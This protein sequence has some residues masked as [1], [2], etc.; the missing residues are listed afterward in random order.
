MIRI[1]KGNLLRGETEALVNTVNCVGPMGKGIALQFKKDIPGKFRTLSERMP[2]RG[3]AARSNACF[4][5]QKD[6]WTK[7]YH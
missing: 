2:R 6:D 4:R 1:M 5:N 3:C 7:I